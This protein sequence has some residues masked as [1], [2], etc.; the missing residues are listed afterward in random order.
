MILSN[1]L[2]AINIPWQWKHS[3]NAQIKVIEHHNNHIYTIG[4]FNNNA[5][6]FGG[7]NIPNHGG[8]DMLIMK[9]DSLG[10]LIWATSIWGS[11]QDLATSIKVNSNNE[12]I[13]VGHTNSPTIN[14]SGNTLTTAGD[15]DIFIAKYDLSGNYIDAY[16]YNQTGNEQA[17]DMC[18]DHLNNIYVASNS[19]IKKYTNAGTLAWQRNLQAK[20][21]HYSKIDS[22]VIAVGHFT[23][24]LSLGN[25][26]ITGS[27]ADSEIYAA[28]LTLDNIPTWLVN[29]TNDPRSEFS[30]RSCINEQSGI[31]YIGYTFTSLTSGDY[32][33]LMKISP[34]GNVSYTGLSIFT[35]AAS[36]NCL[37]MSVNDSLIAFHLDF[38]TPGE[39]GGIY[40]YNTNNFSLINKYDYINYYAVLNFRSVRSIYIVFHNGLGR[41]NHFALG[42]SASQNIQICAGVQTTLTGTITGGEGPLIYSWLPTTGLNNTN[43][44]SVIFTPMNNISYTLT[45]TDSAGQIARDTFNIVVDTP[46]IPQQITS[47]FPTFCK[48][49]LLLFS[50]MPFPVNWQKYLPPPNNIWQN[51][52]A[53]T[54]RFIYSPGKYLYTNSNT[55]GVFSDTID[56]VPIANVSAM[57]SPAAVCVGNTAV[58]SGSGAFNYIWSGGVIDNVPFTPLTTQ[59]YTVT[60][61]DVNGCANMS[62]VQLI[63]NSLPVIANLKSVPS[64]ICDQGNAVLSLDTFNGD[65]L[66]WSPNTFLNS[67]SG[68]YIQVNNIDTTTT[69]TVTLTDSNNCTSTANITLPVYQPSA[70]T[71][72][73]TLCSN[74]TPF[75][76]NGQS[77]QTSGVY[78]GHRWNAH[79]CDSLCTLNLII[80]PSP[81]ADITPGND[82][83]I[84][85]TTDYILTAESGFANYEWKLNG[86]TISNTS[87]ANISEVGT[88]LATL[89]VTNNLC[90]SA[91]DQV[92]VGVKPQPK[93]ALIY[94]HY[95]LLCSNAGSIYYQWF[96][97]GRLLNYS[98]SVITITNEGL[99]KVIVKNG[100]DCEA[101]DSLWI[102]VDM[103]TDDTSEVSLFPNPS[104]GEFNINYVLADSSD[105][106]IIMFDMNG[107]AI[108]TFLKDDSQQQGFHRQLYNLDK[109]G[110]ESGVYF[111][112]IKLGLDTYVKKLLYHR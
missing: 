65:V 2:H 110:I 78:V 103:L 50:N 72:D 64:F 24:I 47:Q 9:W 41:L 61:T 12:L 96:Q 88:H 16:I 59:I 99:Y 81:I 30:M 38:N 54:D 63:V 73:T 43:S 66:N 10:N 79:G 3:F 31:L 93:P 90:C 46:I 11:L 35:M 71:S 68:N 86:S 18:V 49:S 48:D 44:N 94:H 37:S 5:F 62:A 87:S 13:V 27:G 33:R 26:S 104:S 29:V 111:F 98:D 34:S 23:S 25:L 69:Y 80:N 19:T 85:A 7:V 15:G 105:V 40:I 92:Y 42:G 89:T 17:V 60:G 109:L 106:S 57:A 84:C 14:V 91:S 102:N 112:R 51:M 22:T 6:I 83:T 100:F 95:S 76:W 107:R 39:I 52:G 67:S 55:C 21:L 36:N 75:L 56:V 32:F 101:A 20:N 8:T 28:K 4:T 97:D 1:S 77:L 53:S 82:T 108:H 58:L 70:S 74:Q 45:V